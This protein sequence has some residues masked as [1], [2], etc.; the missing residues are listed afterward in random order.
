MYLVIDLYPAPFAILSYVTLTIATVLGIIG[1]VETFLLLVITHTWLGLSMQTVQTI[2]FL[3]LSI[4]GHLTLFVA[5]TKRPFFTRPFPAFTLLAAILGTQVIAAL[6]AG[7]GIF[8][9]AI[10]WSYVGLIWVYCLVWAVIE[11]IAKLASINMLEHRAQFKQG[12]LSSVNK[13]LH[14]GAGR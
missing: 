10:P 9:T 14:P 8:V 5:R 11:D 1:V 2:I 13:A 3:K 6:I 12:F 7:L 4:A